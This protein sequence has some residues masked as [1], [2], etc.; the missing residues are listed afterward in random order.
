M[1]IV[2]LA[3]N[4]ATRLNCVAGWKRANFKFAKLNFTQISV[5]FVDTLLQFHFELIAFRVNA[6]LFNPI[7]ILLLHDDGNSIKIHKNR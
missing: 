1:N 5:E 2:L 7:I 4:F 3:W 6:L